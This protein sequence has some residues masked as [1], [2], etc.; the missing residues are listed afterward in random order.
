[1]RGKEKDIEQ[2]TIENLPLIHEE[3]IQDGATNV[4]QTVGHNMYILAYQV[5]YLE[6]SIPGEIYIS[7]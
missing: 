4:A 1:M 6:L 7:V 3:D 5:Q 2:K